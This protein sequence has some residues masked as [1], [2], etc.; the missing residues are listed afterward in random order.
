VSL[1]FFG[2]FLLR[3]GELEEI[4]LRQALERMQQ[5][6]PFLGDLAVAA[7]FASE[8]DCRR[9]SDEQRRTDLPFGELAVRMGVLNSIELEELLQKQQRT[10][11]DLSAALVLQGC[12]P[13]ERVRVLFDQ[14]KAEQQVLPEA[15]AALP[16]GLAG[17]PT[18]A[19]ALALFPRLCRR[20]AS[21]QVKVGSG[22]HLGELP[23][24]V[25]VCSVD[26]VGTRPLRTSLLVSRP[27]G[28]KLAQGLLG[29]QLDVLASELALEAVAEF[30]NVWMGNVVAALEQQAHG[31]RL[32]PPTYCVLPT[33][34]IRFPVVTENEGTGEL[35]L[36]PL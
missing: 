13:E 24:H 2:Q 36:E 18:A 6:N 26:V 21:L 34:G 7:G 5:L 16:A 3:N 27:F 14:W 33:K 10:R 8:A 25:L 12:L 11:V 20:V 35:V 9:V 30:L 23:D 19:T 4:Q 31:V 32:E 15:S 1:E 29:M 22:D 28:E 17:H